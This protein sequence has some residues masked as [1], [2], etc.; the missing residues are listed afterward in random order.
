MLLWD[1]ARAQ[2]S[3]LLQQL[4]RV[5]CV[6]WCMVTWAKPSETMQ[7][8]T[9][10]RYKFTLWIHKWQGE[11]I[12]LGLFK[13]WGWC[14]RAA[15]EIYILV[16]CAARIYRGDRRFDEKNKWRRCGVSHRW[17]KLCYRVL[18]GMGF[19]LGVD[20]PCGFQGLLHDCHRQP[21]KV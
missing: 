15:S 11:S 1:G 12:D 8:S 16:G 21:W 6:W 9:M 13:C 2:T 5:L 10:C 20:F 19:I 3:R 4:V 14:V 7:A 17:Y 18:G